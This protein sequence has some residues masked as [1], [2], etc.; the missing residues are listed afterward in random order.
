MTE[1][2]EAGDTV[3]FASSKQKMT[4]MDVGLNTGLVFCAWIDDG[5]Y[6]LEA[7]PAVALVRV[8]PVD[9]DEYEDKCGD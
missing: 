9:H 7:F 4:V 3:A 6:R 2:P 8:E 5:C 1:P